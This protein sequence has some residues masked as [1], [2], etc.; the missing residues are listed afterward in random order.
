M[1]RF[2]LMALCGF[3]FSLAA[4]AQVQDRPPF[5]MDK[6]YVSASLSNFNLDY[7][8]AESLKM[9]F[10]AKGGY[11]FEDDWM[12]TANLGYDWRKVGPNA[13]SLGAGLRYYIEQ[14]GLYLGAGA[15][16][17]HRHDF[18]DFLPSVQLGYAFFLNRTVT[19]EP[20]VYYNLS[21]K[22]HVEYSGFGIRIGLGIYFE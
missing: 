7:T 19:L 13:L 4:N 17:V 6:Y 5:G 21:L 1:K 3:V 11:L 15:N 2:F 9:D 12:V 8:K 16:Y 10:N 14:N 22:D 18:D 20:E